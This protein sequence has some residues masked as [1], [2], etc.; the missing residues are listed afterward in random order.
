MNINDQDYEVDHIAF[1]EV[2]AL[3]CR[4]IQVIL[5]IQNEI[6]ANSI[7]FKF[8]MLSMDYY[9]KQDTMVLVNTEEDELLAEQAK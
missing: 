9:N 4:I 6:R 7:L 5:E 2:K 3:V 8:R 1:L